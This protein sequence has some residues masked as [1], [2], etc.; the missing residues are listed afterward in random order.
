MSKSSLKR[1]AV[2]AISLAVIAPSMAPAQAAGEIKIG[3]ITSTSGPLAS[4]G[5]A[6]NEGLT[7]GLELLHRRKDGH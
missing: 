1:L 2:A 6:Y 3:V 7:W 5:V 4:Y